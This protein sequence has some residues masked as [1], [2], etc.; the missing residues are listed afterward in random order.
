MLHV[1]RP[2]AQHAIPGMFDLI[3]DAAE[4]MEIVGTT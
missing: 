3:L 1:Y 4:E 2:Y